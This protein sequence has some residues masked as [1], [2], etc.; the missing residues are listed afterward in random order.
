M[1]R[2]EHIDDLICQLASCDRETLTR[3]FISFNSTFPIDCTPEFLA[4]LSDDRLR[5][6]FLAIC[7]Q[8]RRLPTFMT[9]LRV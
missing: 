9:A 4:T 6:I 3:E 8:N 5:H 7:V 1:L 2:H